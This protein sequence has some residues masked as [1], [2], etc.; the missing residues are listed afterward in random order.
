M[1]ERALEAIETAFGD[2]PRPG[3]EDLLH[4][5]C[6]DDTDIAPLYAFE[7]WRDLQDADV[8]GTVCRVVVPLGGRI[9]VLPARLPLL[10]AA[11]SEQR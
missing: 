5:D 11:Q 3:N 7:S 10:R 4:P 9:S 6:A 1:N 2:V 8:I